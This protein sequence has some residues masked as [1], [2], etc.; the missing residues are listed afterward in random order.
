MSAVPGFIVITYCSSSFVATTG[1]ATGGIGRSRWN[2]SNGVE[3]AERANAD[4]F[5]P[6]VRAILSKSN[7]HT[8]ATPP[9]PRVSAA[10]RVI[11]SR[12]QSITRVPC[13]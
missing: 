11:P 9:K 2:G 3:A 6:L 8:R 10:R 5:L 12:S 1:V 7:E 13:P 4:V